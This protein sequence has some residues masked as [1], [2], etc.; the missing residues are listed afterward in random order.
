MI[1][2]F[3]FDVGGVLVKQTQ[4]CVRLAARFFKVDRES[5]IQAMAKHRAPVQKGLISEKEFWCQVA[6]ELGRELGKRKLEE[7]ALL[8]KK[9]R[10]AKYYSSVIRLVKELKNKGFK[11]AVLTNTVPSHSEDD[12]YSLFD[13]K[14]V[15]Y[16]V[17]MR[18]P[19]KEIYLYALKKLKTKPEETV[20]IDDKEENI[21]AAEEVGMHVILAKSPRQVRNKVKRMFGE[22]EG[23]W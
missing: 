12:L 22:K 2:A 16:K 9:C 8:F 18:K 19:E 3:I 6:K 7:A 5:I 13:V 1:K 15:S 11:T 10:P 21:K 4:K 17:R 20:F 23:F 14:I